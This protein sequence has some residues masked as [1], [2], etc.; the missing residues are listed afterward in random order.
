M[1]D[2]SGL[3]LPP[4]NEDLKKKEEK[5]LQGNDLTLKL[6]LPDGTTESM[7][8]KSSTV[9]GYVKILLSEK[10]KVPVGRISL[11][12]KNKPM[13]NP[14]SFC[15]YEGVTPPEIKVIVKFNNGAEN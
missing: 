14:M 4:K 1:S 10:L 12:F 5:E 7:N 6:L 11:L 8:V 15:D 9:V 13:I 3:T 2:A